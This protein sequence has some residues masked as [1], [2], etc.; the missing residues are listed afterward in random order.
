ML[1][2]YGKKGKIW[3]NYL[4]RC[5]E[6]DSFVIPPSLKVSIKRARGIRLLLEDTVDDETVP[7]GTSNEATRSSKP[8][9]LQGEVSNIM[10]NLSC[11]VHMQMI[12]L[13]P[14]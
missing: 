11:A 9:H 12:F 3:R 10:E 1:E 2:K 7:N 8:P 14:Q 6:H 5:L 4:K 13:R